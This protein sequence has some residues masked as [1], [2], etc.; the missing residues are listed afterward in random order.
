MLQVQDENNEAIS[1]M[2]LQ[3]LELTLNSTSHPS[4]HLSHMVQIAFDKKDIFSSES[5]DHHLLNSMSKL[6]LESANINENFSKL[7]SLTLSESDPGPLMV[8]LT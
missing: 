8:H 6:I 3:S 2:V 5:V 4:L 7:K 1:S